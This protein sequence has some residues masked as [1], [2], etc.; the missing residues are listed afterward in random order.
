MR[1]TNSMRDSIIN[2]EVNNKYHDKR[3]EA[4]KKFRDAIEEL[5]KKAVAAGP[6]IPQELIDSNYIRLTDSARIEYSCG[7][8]DNYYQLYNYYPANINGNK[9]EIKATKTVE[10]LRDKLRSIRE[11]RIKFKRSLKQILYAFTTDKQVVAAIPEFKHYFANQQKAQS[12][13]VIPAEQ[14]NS[15]RKQLVKPKGE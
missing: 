7:E 11:E 2:Q 10:K 14:I 1:L 9:I 15:I 5:A 6:K 12:M 4:E 13:A 3:N 8:K